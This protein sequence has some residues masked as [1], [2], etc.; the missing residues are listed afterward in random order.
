[1]PALDT[2]ELR[3]A[4]VI[5]DPAQTARLAGV[6]QLCTDLALDCRRIR[7]PVLDH[8]A[9]LECVARTRAGCSV[10]DCDG[11]TVRYVGKPLA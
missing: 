3:H 9:V 11:Y 10:E 2:M 7:P 4:L 1:M 5:N 8:A 6:R